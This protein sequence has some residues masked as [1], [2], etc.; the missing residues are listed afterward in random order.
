MHPVTFKIHYPESLSRGL[1][2]LKVFFGGLYV[3]IPHGICLAGLGIANAFVVFIAFWAILFTG[4]YP[5]GMFDFT[6]GVMRWQY[7]VM[8][9]MLFMTDTYPPFTMQKTDTDAVMYD[10]QYPESLGRG[11]LIIKALFGYFYAV[12]PH[13]I[14]LAFLG[15]GAYVVIFISFWAILF[16]GRY[17]EGMFRYIEGFYRWAARLGAYFWMTDVYPPFTG[18]EV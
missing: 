2:L 13:A 3:G 7:R 11:K 4:K 12:I 1:L 10:V 15:I 8:A 18:K 17:P 6:V 5:K 14:C 9:Y 16:T